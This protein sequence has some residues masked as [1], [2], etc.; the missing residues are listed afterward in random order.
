MQSSF[1]CI[2][3]SLMTNYII[4]PD[5]SGSGFNVGVMGADG[6]RQTLLGF[7]TEADAEAWIVQDKRLGRSGDQSGDSYDAAAAGD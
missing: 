5:S 1:A 2:K 4:I 6:A 7:E 3:L